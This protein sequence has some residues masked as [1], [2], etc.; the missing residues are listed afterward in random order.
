MSIETFRYDGRR[1][2]IVGGA[3]GMGAAT[4]KLVS[5]LGGEVVVMDVADVTFPVEQVIQVDLR[6]RASVD[7]AVDQAA[8]HFD[9]VFCCAGVADGTPGLMAINFLSQRHLVERLLER[10]ALPRGAAIGVISSVAGLGWQMDMEILGEFLDTD[11]D[12]AVAWIEAHEGTNDY[13]F[14]KKAMNAWV[15][16][17]AL[18]LIKRGIRINAIE[19]GPT[20][21]PLARANADLW[22]GFAADY[23]KAAGIDTL[24]PEE[25]A[26]PL[27]FLCS[28]A[29]SG[30]NG[31]SFLVDHG[32]INSGI[33][34]G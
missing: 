28:P 16:R 12:S 33:A 18:P 23:N 2:L 30:V 4:A 25:M 34:G 19:P 17:Q 13:L 15:A 32:Q 24:S 26:A 14:S 5:E 20:D 8:G 6:E 10:D 9:A 21:T 1:A 31:I 3:T 11:W 29:A 27:A 7:A 22:L